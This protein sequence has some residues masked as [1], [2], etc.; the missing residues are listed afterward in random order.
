MERRMGVF[1]VCNYQFHNWVHG[2]EKNIEL[3][4]EKYNKKNESKQT[5]RPL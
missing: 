5:E 1:G 3:Q 4:D 2:E